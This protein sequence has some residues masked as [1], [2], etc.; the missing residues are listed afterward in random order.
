MTP[1]TQGAEPTNWV[2]YFGGSVWEFDEATGEYY[3]HLFSKKQP[4]LN[5]ENPKVREEVFAI[6][7]W[8]LKKGID[9]FRMDVINMISKDP[10]LPDGRPGTAGTTHGLLADG[11]PHFICG[12]RLHEFLREMHE[13]FI[14]LRLSAG[15]LPSAENSDRVVP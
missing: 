4:D 14:Q 11:S 5:W 13:E 1:G 6:M 15:V 12:P 2:S 8:W 10:S 3:L 7:D 9:G